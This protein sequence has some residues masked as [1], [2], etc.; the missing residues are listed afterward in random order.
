MGVFRK[1]HREMVF[2]N[3]DQIRRGDPY[4]LEIFTIL[5]KN[6]PINFGKSI[7]FIFFALLG[8]G[9]IR[10]GD[11]YGLEFCAILF[12]NF[13]INFGKSTFSFFFVT[14]AD[15]SWNLVSDF[16]DLHRGI[17]I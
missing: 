3:F 11:P 8:F 2:E 5:V 10:R 12:K 17:P 14:F 7:F 4:G 13:P 16:F 15:L 1:P 6:F 9:K